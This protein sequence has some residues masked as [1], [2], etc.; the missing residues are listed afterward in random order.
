M[1]STLLQVGELASKMQELPVTL[2][3]ALMDD[4]LTQT[5]DKRNA[6]V[7]PASVDIDLDGEGSDH[8]KGL[9]HTMPSAENLA[10]YLGKTGITANTTVVV[11]DTRGIFSA[12]RVWWMLKAIGHKSVFLL[13]GGQP[14][15]QS[16]GLPVSEQQ[17]YGKLTYQASPSEG[18]F[19]NADSVVSALESDVQLLDARNKPRFRGEVSEP[20]VG[21]RSGHM[22]GA[23]N[24]PYGD[25][26]S[27]GHYLPIDSLK[28][29]FDQSKIDLSLPIICTCGSGITACVVAFAALLCGAKDVSVYDGSWSEWGASE[30]YPVA[31]G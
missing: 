22:P 14:A 23:F 29:I 28:R 18:W 2:L 6:M 9:P 4:P 11:Y 21:V 8:S 1:S 27:D 17:F 19:V 10:L 24:I 7:L 16:A 15:W 3:R 20:R 13:D 12:P 31:V 5:P 26:L 30:S 25:L